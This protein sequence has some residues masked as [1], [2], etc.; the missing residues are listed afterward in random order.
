MGTSENLHGNMP[1]ITDTNRRLL[2]QLPANQSQD[3]T[4][5]NYTTRRGED[6][7]FI[8]DHF[9]LDIRAFVQHEANRGLFRLEDFT[10]K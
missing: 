5:F 8:V 2:A 4:C 10:Y 6:V 7:A 3:G 1:W 9:D